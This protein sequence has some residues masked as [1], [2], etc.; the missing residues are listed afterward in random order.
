MIVIVRVDLIFTEREVIM[1]DDWLA[2]GSGS[3]NGDLLEA[4]MAGIDPE[5]DLDVGIISTEPNHG[6]KA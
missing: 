4:I 2:D 1:P 5:L 6:G 3:A